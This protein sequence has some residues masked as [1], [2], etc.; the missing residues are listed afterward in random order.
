MWWENFYTHTK[1]SLACSSSSSSLT[2]T[3]CLKVTCTHD[4]EDQI[5]RHRPGRTEGCPSNARLT[6]LCRPDRQPTVNDYRL[7]ISWTDTAPLNSVTGS[8]LEVSDRTHFTC[9]HEIVRIRATSRRRLPMPTAAHPSVCLATHR[10]T[11]Q[12]EME[13]V[14]V[15]RRTGAI[16]ETVYPRLVVASGVWHAPECSP[17]MFSLDILLATIT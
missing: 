13:N 6:A 15:V 17:W 14:L 10:L 12:L 4:C 9:T 3:F 1:W 5:R 11:M 16:V 2:K 8:F 7:W